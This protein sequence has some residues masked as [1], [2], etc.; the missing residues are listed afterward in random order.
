ME[1]RAAKIVRE[2]SAEE[3]SGLREWAERYV[4]LIPHYHA[5]GLSA[6]RR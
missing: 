2:L 3:Q 6:E 1:R 4:R 5:Q